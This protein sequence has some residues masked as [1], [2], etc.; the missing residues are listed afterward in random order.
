MT[1]DAVLAERLELWRE[2]EALALDLLVI[3]A[4]EGT[5]LTLEDCRRR[6]LAVRATVREQLRELLTS[7][8]ETI[9]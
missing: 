3:E 4:R 9:H 7:G 8:H 1:A 6:V 2:L 5:S